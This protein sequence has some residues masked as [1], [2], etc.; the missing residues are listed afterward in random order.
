[1]GRQR[2]HPPIHHLT[3]ANLPTCQPTSQAAS[4]GAQVLPCPPH[5][6][7][8]SKHQGLRQTPSACLL[9]HL[10]TPSK[11][12]RQPWS[13]PGPAGKL[14]PTD[15]G[16]ST[17]NIFYI[18]KAVMSQSSAVTGSGVPAQPRAILRGHKAQ[19]HAAVFI[20][21]GERLV[22]GDAEGFVAV[23]DLTIMR[24]RAVW[25]AHEDVMLGVRDW[26][27][28][29]LITYVPRHPSCRSDRSQQILI[30]GSLLRTHPDFCAF[31]LD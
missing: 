10:E 19:I 11:S 22:T 12:G 2:R 23:W 5:S 24:P 31:C 17:R 27:H 4:F 7:K 15:P 29:R 21:G 20:R 26:G 13:R 3:R 6:D 30:P 18:R 1:M 25:K 8:P 28:E 9:W 14:Q 16:S